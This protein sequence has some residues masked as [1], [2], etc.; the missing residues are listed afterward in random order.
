MVRELMVGCRPNAICTYVRISRFNQGGLLLLDPVQKKGPL[1]GKSTNKVAYRSLHSKSTIRNLLTVIEVV[2][3]E[4]S[5]SRE[6]T[7]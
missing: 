2:F 5:F 4:N 3:L 7:S 6:L 1:T